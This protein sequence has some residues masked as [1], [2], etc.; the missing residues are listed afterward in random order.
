LKTS[1]GFK[2]KQVIESRA[3]QKAGIAPDDLIIA[4]NRRQIDLNDPQKLID[5]EKTGEV[6]PIHIFRDDVLYTLDFQLIPASKDTAYLSFEPSVK[7]E[8][9]KWLD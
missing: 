8:I 1:K 9:Q 2:V 6:I 4:I 5:M 7:S 3:A